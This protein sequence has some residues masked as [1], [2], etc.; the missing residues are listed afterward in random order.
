MESLKNSSLSINNK[1]TVDINKL[2]IMKTRIIDV[3]K[4]LDETFHPEYQEDY[5]NS[6]FLLGD[7]GEECSGVLT[8]LDLTAEVL[9]DFTVMLPVP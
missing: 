9:A 3:V 7:S 5:D 6:G 4:Y 2:T 8:A 1:V